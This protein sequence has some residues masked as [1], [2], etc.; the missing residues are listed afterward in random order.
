[1]FEEVTFEMLGNGW[2]QFHVTSIWVVNEPKERRQIHNNIR[3]ERSILEV[4]YGH[5][6]LRYA[7]QKLLEKTL[8][9]HECGQYGAYVT[10]VD[11]EINFPS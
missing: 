10:N 8:N 3:H 9:N 11:E 2:K 7:T 5:V 1:M 4:S 6:A